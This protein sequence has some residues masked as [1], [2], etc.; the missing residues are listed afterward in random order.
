MTTPA[1]PATDDPMIL[2]EHVDKFFGSFQALKDIDLEVGRKEVVVVIGPS[3]SG[4][5]TLI[6]CV[7]RLEQHQE[8]QIFVEG[9][10]L[11]P[12][13][14]DIERYGAKSA[15]CFSNSIFFRI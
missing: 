11:T 5:S 2:M 7:N 13:F 3:G 1:T 12:G 4:K 15:W 9:I 8:G 10:E 14:K 6:R